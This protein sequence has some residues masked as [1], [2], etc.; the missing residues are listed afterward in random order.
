M[1]KMY[2]YEGKMM[3]VGQ[4]CKLCGLA[5]N[6]VRGRMNRYGCT[7]EEAITMP[8]GKYLPKYD[9]HGELLTRE[10]IADRAG[11]S[12][13]S[14]AGYMYRYGLTAVE[15]ADFLIA[16][17]AEYDYAGGRKTLKAIAE[18]GHI[19][20]YSLY[21]MVVLQGMAPEESER[22]AIVS[23]GKITP[24]A[25]ART[26]CGEI[27]N[28]VVPELLGFREDD[29]GVYHFGSVFYRY[30]VSFPNPG[31]AQMTAIYRDP[32]HGEYISSVWDYAITKDSIQY[33]GRRE[34]WN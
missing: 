34:T 19:N 22:R 24:C 12:V 23:T 13:K 14:L 18:T 3:S 21:T 29:R 27:F 33:K 32:E 9:Y 17:D 15:A 4:A 5:V 25:V 20:L 2:A 28:G 26:L 10:E 8:K 30:E 16:C 11:V 7:L 1:V 6:T 31:R